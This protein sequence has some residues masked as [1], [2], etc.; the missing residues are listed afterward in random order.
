MRPLA[1]LV[2]TVTLFGILS[3]CVHK[4]PVIIHPRGPVI[5]YG[6]PGAVSR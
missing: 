3:G 2:A 4:P 1:K 6:P 5:D